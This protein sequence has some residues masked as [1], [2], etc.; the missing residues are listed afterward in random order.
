MDARSK[1][2]QQPSKIPNEK[3]GTS[4]F[5]SVPAQDLHVFALKIRIKDNAWIFDHVPANPRFLVSSTDY[6][7]IIQAGFHYNALHMA[8]RWGNVQV[9]QLV[10][11]SISSTEF[12]K[13]LYPDDDFRSIT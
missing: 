9:V 6:P 11:S 7:T 13:S 12:V 5:P 1:V 8:A 10:L 2:Q 3:S 4:N